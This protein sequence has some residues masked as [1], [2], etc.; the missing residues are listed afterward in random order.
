MSRLSKNS[1]RGRVAGAAHPGVNPDHHHVSPSHHKTG[2]GQTRAVQNRDISHFK[3]F[4]FSYKDPS[5]PTIVL[6]L[7]AWVL[8]LQMSTGAHCPAQCVTQRD[9]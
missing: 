6:V 8:V 1:V 4:S 2:P 7:E 3:Y 5:F 9:A